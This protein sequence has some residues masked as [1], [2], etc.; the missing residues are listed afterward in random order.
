MPFPELGPDPVE[1]FRFPLPGGM[2]RN[3]HR[4]FSFVSGIA[5][6][7]TCGA[8]LALTGAE[9]DLPRALRGLPLRGYSFS[10]EKVSSA[11]MAGARVSVKLSSR[12][13]AARHLPEI[14]SLLRR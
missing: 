11:G 4:G 10:V 13:G 14:V 2:R 5:G 6:D 12:K 1:E 7:M 8:L 3:I 9:K